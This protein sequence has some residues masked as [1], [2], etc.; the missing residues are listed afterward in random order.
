MILILKVLIYNGILLDFC[1][2]ND[3]SS[4]HQKRIKKRYRIIISYLIMGYNPYCF[5][6]N[7]PSYR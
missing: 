6:N 3:I 2:I 1:T 4:K 7:L 5:L